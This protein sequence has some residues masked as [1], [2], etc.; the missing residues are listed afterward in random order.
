MEA[1]PEEPPLTP[2]RLAG[3]QP[4][5]G[6]VIGNLSPAFAQDIGLDDTWNGVVVLEV[7]RNSTARRFGFRPGD[8]LRVL[9]DWDIVSAD[10]LEK[11]LS[12]PL[13]SWALV[14]ERGGRLRSIDVSR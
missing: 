8:I 13:D 11:R 2:R 1:P 4:L 12:E 10:A 5:A 9:N 6:A 7:P 14:I 3:N